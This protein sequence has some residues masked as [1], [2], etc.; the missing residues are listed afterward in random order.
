M[1][2]L[3]LRSPPPQGGA[4]P[5]MRGCTRL[6]LPCALLW[7]LQAAAP[8]SPAKS[9]AQRRD[10]RDPARGADF[11]RIYSGTVSLSTE[12]I[13]SFN[14]TSQP[15]QVRHSLPSL[16][17]Q[18]LA[19]SQRPVVALGL[20]GIDVGR[21]QRPRYSRSPSPSKQSLPCPSCRILCYRPQGQLR[22][23]SRLR[24]P[25]SWNFWALQR[26]WFPIWSAGPGPLLSLL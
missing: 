6:A 1:E 25:G 19:R 17:S 18:E 3:A 24:W 8:G 4:A 22:L 23:L 12:N 20:L 14:Y 5:T 2:G 15:G 10:P 13:Y 7:L 26:R 11:D 21:P 9:L 16:H